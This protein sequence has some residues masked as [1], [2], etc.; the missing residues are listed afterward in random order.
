[1]SYEDWKDKRDC[2]MPYFV[3][4]QTISAQA[5]STIRAIGLRQTRQ[6]YVDMLQTMPKRLSFITLYSIIFSSNLEKPSLI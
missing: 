5:I 6:R 3:V 4:L 2:R 1:M